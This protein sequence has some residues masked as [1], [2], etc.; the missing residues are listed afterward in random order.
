VAG[1]FI[2]KEFGLTVTQLGWAFGVFSFSY[3]LMQAPSG[4]VADRLGGGKI[5]APAMFGWSAF[6][7]LTAAAYKL[8]MLIG[9][10]FTFG[11]L[12]ASLSPA[13]ASIFRENV[14]EGIRST[15]FGLFLSGGR[16][17]G[18]FTPALTAAIVLRL[19]WRRR[20]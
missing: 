11:A 5:V 15:V 7:A 8:P 6:T 17:G 9:I 18:A 3:A 12:E 20:F 13:V 2:R 4:I 19:C 1:P 10:R 16:L 14:R